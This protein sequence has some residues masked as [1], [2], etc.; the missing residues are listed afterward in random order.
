MSKEFA[1]AFTSDQPR[2]DL[3]ACL[4]ADAANRHWT[5]SVA[6]P[7]LRGLI[8]GYKP[9]IIVVSH[10]A[11]PDDTQLFRQLQMLSPN[12]LQGI[13]KDLDDGLEFP[14]PQSLRLIHSLQLNPA[15]APIIF[16]TEQHP[17]PMVVQ[18]CRRLGATAVWSFGVPDSARRFS[19]FINGV[20]EFR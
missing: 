13:V 20:Q 1:I 14:F 12:E 5:I 2:K 7:D 10:D 19:A 4:A 8:E 17:G 6:R 3:M 9:S 16:L 18:L 15:P 11:G